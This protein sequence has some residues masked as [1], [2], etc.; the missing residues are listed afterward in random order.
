MSIFCSDFTPAKPPDSVALQAECV[1][2]HFL[3][4]F[5][6]G[7]PSVKWMSPYPVSKCSVVAVVGVVGSCQEKFQASLILD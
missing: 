2:C 6:L 5:C 4:F 1:D 3:P 7:S